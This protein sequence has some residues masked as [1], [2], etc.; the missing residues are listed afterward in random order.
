MAKS[1]IHLNSSELCNFTAHIFQESEQNPSSDSIEILLNAIGNSFH[2]DRVFICERRKNGSFDNT[3]EWCAPGVVSA[4]DVFQNSPASIFASWYSMYN[5]THDCFIQNVS[6]LKNT[7]LDLFYLLSNQGIHTVLSDQIRYHGADYGIIGADNP[8]PE[9]IDRFA[10]ALRMIRPYIAS[11]LYSRDL[12][13]TMLESGFID[14]LTGAGSRLSLSDLLDRISRTGPLGLLAV[15]LINLEQYNRIHGHHAGDELLKQVTVLLSNIFGPNFVF[16]IDGDEFLALYLEP[17]DANLKQKQQY[18]EQALLE[19]DIHAACVSVYENPWT[20]EFD[21]LRRRMDLSL[22]EKKASILR[23]RKMDRAV[24]AEHYNKTLLL[25]DLV[26]NS[27]TALYRSSGIRLSPKYNSLSEALQLRVSNIHPEDQEIFRLF[28]N[29]DQIRSRFRRQPG[30]THSIVY[31]VKEGDGWIQTEESLEL[32]EKSENVFRLLITIRAD[33]A[34]R[35]FQPIRDMIIEPD[36]HTKASLTMYRN[37]EFFRR[38]AYWLSQTDAKRVAM[39]ALDINHF[40]LYNSMFG[41]DAGN[42][43]L[44]MIQST[45]LEY[46][47]RY[48]GI[49]G[50][51][52]NDNF[53]ILLPLYRISAEDFAA[54]IEE[55]LRKFRIPTLFMPYAGVYICDDFSLLPS[56]QYEFANLA[57]DNISGNLNRHVIFFDKEAYQQQ[58]EEQFLLL[59]IEDGLGKEEFLFYLQP[60]V[61]MRTG[62]LTS[63]EALVR[64]NR[65]GQILSPARFVETMERA[66]IIYRLDLMIL[67][68]VCEWLRNRLDQNLP[69]IPVSVNLS[70]ADFRYGKITEEVEKIIDAWRIPPRLIQIEITESAFTEDDGEILRSISTLQKHGH[71]ILLDDFGK[72][73]SSLN[74]LSS[75]NFDILKLDKQF[76]DAL[77]NEENRSIVESIIRMAH[78]IGLLVVAEG[79]ESAEQA[80]IL[81]QL[82]CYYCQGYHFYKP[83]PKEDAGTLIND[84]SIIQKEPPFISGMRFGRLNFAEQINSIIGP[85]AIFE[86]TDKS[87]HMLQ[88]NDAYGRILSEEA[89]NLNNNSDVMRQLDQPEA[90]VRHSFAMADITPGYKS[91]ASFRKKDGQFI[92]LEATIYPV[93]KTDQASFYM[94]SLKQKD[95]L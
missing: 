70:R 55:E 65:N 35:P 57:S 59:D 85:V 44:E 24:S 95:M 63:F 76:I 92:M 10:D 62:C 47:R 38:A 48:H 77:D 83:M 12:K 89:E 78:M 4:R 37:K 23:D 53:A 79:V 7:N 16:R 3:Y 68:Q 50:Y 5:K 71:R 87:I 67:R 72:G 74:S 1:D 32:L 11:L 33:S 49:S 18:L 39:A 90:D 58:K 43:M 73:Y 46:S 75:M 81:M 20:T 22:Y 17:D 2:C 28:W 52:G 27:I 94:V 61:N 31:R 88:M 80:D 51:M 29:Q 14:K 25:A 15:D 45:L 86:V 26:S 34:M 69:V 21:T 64:W 54:R 36:A 93:S 6:E 30:S 66:N 42:H 84:I 8:S 40:K 13:R 56:E 41:R 60:K 91:S 9:S 82:N 19:K